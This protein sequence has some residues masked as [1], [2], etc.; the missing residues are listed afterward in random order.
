M[1]RRGFLKQC[2]VAGSLAEDFFAQRYVSA[3]SMTRTLL[4]GAAALEGVADE[5][6][7]ADQLVRA[8][9]CL[10]TTYKRRLDRGFGLPA[11]EQAFVDEAISADLKSGPTSRGC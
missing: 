11:R 8:R 9:R 6:T 4:E 2:E 5:D 7:L 1:V 10:L 3:Q